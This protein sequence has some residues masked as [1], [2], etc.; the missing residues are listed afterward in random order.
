MKYSLWKTQITAKKILSDLLES[1]RVIN[2]GNCFIENLLK[3]TL[4][5]H[6]QNYKDSCY[7]VILHAIVWSEFPQNS[8]IKILTPSVMEFGDEALGR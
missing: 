7:K 2:R 4:K 3:I 8:C 6:F 1:L 5:I